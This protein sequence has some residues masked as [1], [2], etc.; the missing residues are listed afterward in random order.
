[1]QKSMQNSHP[2]PPNGGFKHKQHS[3][4]M[5]PMGKLEE[6]AIPESE[7]LM[8]EEQSGHEMKDSKNPY[9]ESD[10]DDESTQWANAYDEANPDE[11]MVLGDPL[12]EPIET[13]SVQIPDDEVLEVM[14]DFSKMKFG[15]NTRCRL[16]G[17]NSTEAHTPP[18][19]RSCSFFRGQMP[20]KFQQKCCGG[21]HA[22]ISH[23][24]TC[25]VVQ[26]LGPRPFRPAYNKPLFRGGNPNQK[27]YQFGNQR[28]G[29]PGQNQQG[30]PGRQQQHQNFRV[31]QRPAQGPQ[32]NQPNRQVF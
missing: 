30:Q 25:P 26:K 13:E 14:P 29:Q 32:Y 21:Y 17:C 6:V 7:G 10:E 22:A 31:A 9:E 3:Q 1:M 19:F 11:W 18:Y 28:P 24:T 12:E 27:S 15:D 2:L 4:S 8:A 5:R 20:Q 23:G 16:C